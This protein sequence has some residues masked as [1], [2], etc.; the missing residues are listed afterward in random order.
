MKCYLTD[1]ILPIYYEN[2]QKE[3][4]V[5][6]KNSKPDGKFTYWY[7]S[8]QLSQEMYYK[9]GKLDGKWLGWYENGQ[10][11][12]ERYFKNGYRVGNWLGWYSNGY[13]ESDVYWDYNNSGDPDKDDYL[14]KKCWDK[15]GKLCI[16]YEYGIR[17]N[18]D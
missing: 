17:F 8:G 2:G 13:K 12:W 18:R 10:L 9:E 1:G 5:S 7:E 11:S 4:E 6:F 14:T 15:D 16:H 3:R